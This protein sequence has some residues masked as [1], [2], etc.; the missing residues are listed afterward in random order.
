MSSSEA[1]SNSHAPKATSGE[2]ALSLYVCLILLF[3]A[4]PIFIVVPLAFSSD[5]SL[6]FPPHGFSF[7]WFVNMVNRQEF[8]RAAGLS[9]MLA[10]V[11]TI[12]SLIVGSLAAVGLVRYHFP[13]RDTLLMVFMTPL[14]FPAIVLGA[15]LAL[16]FSPL[17]LLR[18][19][20]GLLLAHMV[21]TFPYCLRTSL[22]TLHEVDKA[23]E[24]AAYTL[25]AN[26]WRTFR[27]VTLP[28]MRPG[29]LAGATFSLIISFDEFTITMFLAG[30]GLMTLPLEMYNYTEFSLD[31]TIAAISTVLLIITSIA[32]VI[33]EKLVGLGK[34]FS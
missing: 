18:N 3:L 33:I 24:E 15:G 12:C 17:G 2:R 21:V 6:S 13:G 9:A 27:H 31:P 25:G 11:A 19:F 10:V 30:P 22:A 28:L 26:R 5:A 14:I 34:Q 23:L 29:L 7:R 8:L 16:M 4:L 20:W 1:L 32:I